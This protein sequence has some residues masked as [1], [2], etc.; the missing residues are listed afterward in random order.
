V[1]VAERLHGRDS[2]DPEAVR[3]RRVG[4]DVDLGEGDPAVAGL[5]LAL[6]HRSEGLAGA[7]PVRP[8][9][10]HDGQLRRALDDVRIEGGV[11]DVHD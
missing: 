8:E 1:P 6:D 11:R 2:A 9:V 5:R 7:A 3:Q 10:D 4:V